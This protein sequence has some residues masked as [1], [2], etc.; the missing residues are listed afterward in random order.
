MDKSVFLPWLVLGPL[1]VVVMNASFFH[2]FNLVINR[3]R[4]ILLFAAQE[5]DT[6]A[7]NL[8]NDR[9]PSAVLYLQ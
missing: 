3:T 2:R 8:E 9:T 5:A 1:L 4:I 7:L 6:V